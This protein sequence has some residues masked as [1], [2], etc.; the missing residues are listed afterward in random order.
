MVVFGRTDA[1]DLCVTLGVRD[2]YLPGPEMGGELGVVARSHNRSH[3]LLNDPRGD[4]SNVL[5][6]FRRLPISYH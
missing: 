6:E 1:R 5:K 4:L 2:G 3:A